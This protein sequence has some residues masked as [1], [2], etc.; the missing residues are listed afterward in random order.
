MDLETSYGETPLFLAAQ[1]GN[2]KIVTML[3]EDGNATIRNVT[4]KW[5]IGNSK[6]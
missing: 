4:T 6:F 2:L 3:R 5:N 1:N